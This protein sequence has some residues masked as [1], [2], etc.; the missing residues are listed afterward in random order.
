MDVDF[1]QREETLSKTLRALA[2]VPVEQRRAFL[3]ESDICAKPL[4]ESVPAIE[5]LRRLDDSRHDEAIVVNSSGG[6]LGIAFRD[7][8]V[9]S[10]VT[11]LFES[12][13]ESGELDSS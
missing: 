13:V 7:T 4:D 2:L 11:S 12:L 9:S 6:Y 10:L 8:I 1:R 3:L 5:A